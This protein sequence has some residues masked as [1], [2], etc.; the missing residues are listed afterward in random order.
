MKLSVTHDPMG[1]AIRDYALTG[2]AQPLLVQSSMFDDDELPVP[3]LFRSAEAMP[4]LEQLALSRCTGRVLDVGAGAGCHALALQERGCDVTAIDISPLS[5]EAMTA[6][7]VRRALCA[8]FFTDDFGANFDT[9]IL[10]MNGT[11]IAGTLP[12]LPTLL[13]RCTALLAPGGKVLTDSSDLRYLFEDEDGTFSPADFDHYYGEV[14]YRMVYGTCR[15]PR[16]DWL[17]VDFDTLARTASACGMTAAK[18]ADGAHFDYLAEL[19]VQP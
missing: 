16:F 8:D 6:R 4:P 5:V 11:G 13:R 14:D 19:R 17:Y 7:G 12:H 18:L 10:L 2:T 3:D 1:R 15:G 9:I